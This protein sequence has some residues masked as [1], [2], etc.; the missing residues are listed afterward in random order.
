MRTWGGRIRGREVWLTRT[1]VMESLRLIKPSKVR[2][3]AV[4]VGGVWFPL[5][6]A[7]GHTLGRPRVEIDTRQAQRVFKALGFRISTPERPLVHLDIQGRPLLKPRPETLDELPAERESLDIGRIELEWSWWEW[8]MDIRGG[9]LGGA[10]VEVP[11]Q[12][13]VY[14]VKRHGEDK[15]LYVGRATNLQARIVHQLVKGTGVHPAG[16][17]IRETEKL[18]RL[19]VRW[20]A[21]DRPA[22]VEEE[23]LRA[24]VEAWEA[25]PEYVLRVY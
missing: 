8:W 2:Q 15:L 25:L 1:Q 11:V 18:G 10:R 24:H 21:T 12:A 13:G 23:L 16:G 20:A 6:Q 9:F 14:E 17:R 5:K 3:L 19:C 22:A 7:L 4:E